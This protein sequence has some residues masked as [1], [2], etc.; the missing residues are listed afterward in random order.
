MFDVMAD[1]LAV[2]LLN[3]GGRQ[4]AEAHGSRASVGRALWRVHARRTIGKSLISIQS[5]REWKMFCA[6][7]IEM[8]D[9]PGDPALRQHGGARPQPRKLTDEHGRGRVRQTEPRD[10][11]LKRLADADIA[12]AEVNTMDDLVGASA[13][14]P[15]RG[16]HAERRG[17][18]IRRRRAIVVGEKRHYGAVPGYRRPHRP[19]TSPRRANI[20]TAKPD[21]DHLRQWIGRT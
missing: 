2:P 8:P 6:K 17:G 3:S 12:F 20:M 19:R 16:R 11:L 13:S 18:A 9:L 10:D 5:E 21:I 1:W 14:A 7:V 15:H 4:S